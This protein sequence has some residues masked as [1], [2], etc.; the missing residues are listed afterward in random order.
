MSGESENDIPVGDFVFER[1]EIKI[2]FLPVVQ[3]DLIQTAIVGFFKLVKS[4]GDIAPDSFVLSNRF[5]TCLI[6]S[7]Q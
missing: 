3:H 4:N 7:F 5:K 6:F 2:F 1:A